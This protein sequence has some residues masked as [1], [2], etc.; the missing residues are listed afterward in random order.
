MQ[1][2]FFNPVSETAMS[3]KAGDTWTAKPNTKAAEKIKYS[4]KNNIVVYVK[5]ENGVTT[6]GTASTGV[7][8][9]YNEK[10]EDTKLKLHKVVDPKLPK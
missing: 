8:T 7:I 5:L 1:K 6:F 9:D 3:N 10:L 4:Y 2:L